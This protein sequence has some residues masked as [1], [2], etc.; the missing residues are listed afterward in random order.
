[1]PSCEYKPSYNESHPLGHYVDKICLEG[2]RYYQWGTPSGYYYGFAA[3]LDNA[4]KPEKCSE[5]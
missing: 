3:I 5:K 4:G 2:H 1:M